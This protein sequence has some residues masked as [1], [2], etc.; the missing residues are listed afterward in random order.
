[1]VQGLAEPVHVAAAPGQPG[2]MY[3]V[4]R[5]GLIR[6]V[7][8]GAV[9]RE[10]LLDI[11]ARVRTEVEEGLHS[12]AFHPE[13]AENGRLFV[14]FNDRRGDL[15]VVEYHVEGEEAEPGSARD[16][17]AVDKSEGVKWHNGGQ[18]QF[19][20]VG[21]LYVS[22]GDSARNQF[23]GLPDPVDTPDP[24]NNAQNLRLL[25]GKLLHLDV[26]EQ[27]PGPADRRVR[28]PEPMALLVRPR[29]GRPVRR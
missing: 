8:D 29:H 12:L 11:R 20:P 9:R 4:E 22:T 3:V 21:L 2:R 7:E 14:A 25:F 18:L 6:V 26:D 15:R 19:G 23:D 27:R 5:A 13:Y 10:P 1:M 28:A 16:L 24:D 17:L